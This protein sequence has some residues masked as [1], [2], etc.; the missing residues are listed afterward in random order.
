MNSNGYIW[1][2]VGFCSTLFMIW[3]IAQDEDEINLLNIVQTTCIGAIG[4]MGGAITLLLA[5]AFVWDE[6]NWGNIVVW[7]RKEF[8]LK[9]DQ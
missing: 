4:C 8:K 5:I 2:F 1:L 3:K 6:K 7:K 9:N